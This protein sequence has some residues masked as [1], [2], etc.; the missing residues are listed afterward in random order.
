MGWGVV[1]SLEEG[2]CQPPGGQR[3]A[4]W[5]KD[6]NGPPGPERYRGWGDTY[7]SA[8]SVFHVSLE[9]SLE[10]SLLTPVLL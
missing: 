6:T 8:Q 7:V 10:S 9:A 1:G 3:D 4:Q 5:H 2:R